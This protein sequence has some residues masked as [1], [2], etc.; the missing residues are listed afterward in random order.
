VKSTRRIIAGAVAA[1]AVVASALLVAPANAADTYVTADQIG[2]EGASYPAGW[3]VGAG[4]TGAIASVAGGLSIVGP[5]QVLNGTPGAIG[6]GLVAVVSAA[7]LGVTS[8]NADFQ[9]PLYT[10]GATDSGF[11]T[12]RPDNFNNAG[13]NPA[14]G[15][16]TS[17]AF[18]TFAAGSSHT[19]ADYDAELAT[20]GTTPE[21][22]AYGVFVPAGETAVVS[23]IT[24][25]G[26]TTRFTPSPTGTATPSTVSLSDFTT[27]GRGV[28]VHLTGFV[29]GETVDGG[30]GDGGSG[31]PTGETYTADANGNVDFTYVYPNSAATLGQYTL[32]GYG[33]TSGVSA[34]ATATVVADATSDPS[35]AP[36][37]PVATPAVPVSGT[38]SFTG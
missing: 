38:A 4:S 3:F 26:T 35:G 10:D 30:I 18:G 15:W 33:E 14:A 34:F 25:N 27:A 28:K 23:S 31:G 16:T 29:P 2:T 8:G 32:S 12:L 36:A 6:D 9:I 13:L 19:L 37:A 5:E 20:L 11:T 24:W 1:A 21:L 7:Q 22:L 17:G